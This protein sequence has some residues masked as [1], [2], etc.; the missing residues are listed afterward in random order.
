MIGVRF[1]RIF[2]ATPHSVSGQTFA[3]RGTLS[4][5]LAARR[6]VGKS[7]IQTPMPSLILSLPIR[8]FPPPNSLH[9]SLSL[10]LSSGFRFL[11]SFED[12]LIFFSFFQ[13]KMEKFSFRSSQVSVYGLIIL[14]IVV[15]SGC[16]RN[17]Y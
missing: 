2:R 14:S 16:K 7:A 12:S 3:P 6:T 1:S 10:S 5:W 4:K 11:L 17:F 9:L 15:I 13:S 8:F